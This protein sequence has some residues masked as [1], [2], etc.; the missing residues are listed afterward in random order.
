MQGVI[1]VPTTKNDDPLLV[2]LDQPTQQL[3]QDIREEQQ[4][5]GTD[6]PWVFPNPRTGKPYAIQQNDLWQAALKRA[7]I[8]DF[9]FHDLRHTFA[10]YLRMAGVDLLTIKEALGHRTLRA[11]ERYAHINSTYRKVAAEALAKAYESATTTQVVAKTAAS[12]GNNVV[13]LEDRRH[14]AEQQG[15][16]RRATKR[17]VVRNSPANLTP[18]APPKSAHHRDG[19]AHAENRHRAPRPCIHTALTDNASHNGVHTAR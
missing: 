16:I 17:T 5:Q 18:F 4:Q 10:S 9:R 13:L 1:T 14:I 12:T 7:G 19:M 2:Y 11:T 8:T 3:L 6:N 15:T